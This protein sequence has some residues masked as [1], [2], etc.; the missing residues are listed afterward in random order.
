ME[1]SFATRKRK[2]DIQGHE[3]AILEYK[4]L[5]HKSEDAV[6]RHKVIIRELKAEIRK[7]RTAIFE[8]ETS[9][10]E[11]MKVPSTSKNEEVAEDVK[12]P[13]Q[14]VQSFSSYING[15]Q[16]TLEEDSPLF[17]I[18]H[19]NAQGSTLIDPDF[20]LN[21]KSVT[22]IKCTCGSLCRD[23]SATQFIYSMEVATRVENARVVEIFQEFGSDVELGAFKMVPLV[24]KRSSTDEGT[25]VTVGFELV[26]HNWQL[27]YPEAIITAA[28]FAWKG[29]VYNPYINWLEKI[30]SG[31][32]GCLVLN[33][34][35]IPVRKQY[36]QLSQLFD[37][38]KRCVA[39]GLFSKQVWNRMFRDNLIE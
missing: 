29:G 13:L 11:E 8:H 34:F 14:R 7:F 35:A 22:D 6:R 1:S 37:V 9:S 27:S 33:L 4:E 17:S 10:R 23:P 32:D 25:T 15:K 21:C 30:L 24:S 39:R 31:C 28:D 2:L 12:V 18:S 3:A 5:I 16:L 19:R 26:I 36:A 38:A 20:F